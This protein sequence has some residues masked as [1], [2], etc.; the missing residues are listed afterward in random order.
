MKS[1]YKI[2][3]YTLVLLVSV[4][5]YAQ[6]HS[7]MIVELNSGAKTLNIQQEITFFNQSSDTLTSIFL[8]DW[9]NSYS[10]K[11]TPLAKRFSDEFYR[12]F[13]LAKEEERG[14]TN[15]LTIIDSNQLFVS[16]ERTEKN[17]DYIEVKLREKLLPNQKTT[18]HLTYITKI[19]SNKFTKYGFNDKGEMNLK[20]WFLTP[21][22]YEN[23]DF[24][25]YSNN[26]L[27]DISNAVSSYDIDLKTPA[28]LEITSDLNSSLPKKTG[29]FSNYKLSGNNRTD[30]SLFVE[31]KSSFISFKNNTTEVLTN[32]KENKISAIQKAVIVD[33]VMDYV[34]TLIGKYPHEK[35]IV[36]QTDYE[37]NPFYGLNQLPSFLSPFTDEFIFEIK[38]LKTY[39]NSYLKNSLRL[40]PRKDNWIY[41]GIQ[42]YAMMKY[43]D[44]NHPNT[45]MFGSVSK[46]RLLKSYNLTNL[47]FNEQ[48]SYFYMLMA[49]KNLD[50]P[51]G[52]PKNSLIKFN[53]QIASKY[54]AGL[55]FRFLDNY[56]EHDEV[57]NS[58]RQFYAENKE[59]QVSR[60]DF[61]TI[62]KFNADKDINWFF[63]TIV[64]SREIID[65]KFADVTKTKDS[66]TFSV[67]NKTNVLIP[68]PVY[69]VKKGEI[70]FKKWL[71]S[72][73]TD[74]TFTIER[75]NADKIVLNYNNEV[76][77]YNLR[78]NW[79]KLEGF[80]PN[81]RP[82]KFVFMK[83]L[84]DPYYN[85]ILYVPS[86]TYNYY[87][88]LSPGLRLHNKTILDKPF[89]FDINPAYSS[90]TDNFSGSAAF[91]VNQNYRNSTLFNVRYSVSG[92]Y[93]HYAP[94]AAYLK[95][96]PTVQL[97]I[98]EENF[99][100]NRKQLILLRQVLVNR[101]KSNFII[102]NST[103]NYSVFD[104]KYF[105]TRTEVT[106]HFSFISDL[107]LSGKFGKIASEI[108]YRKLFESKRQINLRLYA[109][110][111]LY[112]TTA[113]DFFSFALDRPTD[114][115]FDYNYYGR[116][117]SKGFYSQQFIL[118]EGGFKSKLN[119][120]F[121]NQW[122][123]T[124]NGSFNIW[125][126]MELYG[127]IGL[128]KNRS[129]NAR[130]VYDSGIRLN[131]VTDYFEL[132]F[133]IYSNNG[134]EIAQNNYNEKIRFVVTFSPK[135]LINLFNR[136]WF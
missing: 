72:N 4:K 19:P 28:A 45:K 112:N 100:D 114:Y 30:F 13:H 78:N 64:S 97:R 20:N 56:L 41:D 75:K 62:L 117:E 82:V 55:S 115:L 76:P 35:I 110:S 124:L 5:Q 98:R 16:W 12:G 58:I 111:F 54:R 22:R 24:I 81:N 127:D 59:K 108:E 128:I 102:D 48:Y 63:K 66:I 40:N 33:R 113:S 44:E 84:E 129:Q 14:S 68:I 135:T 71:D 52:D 123:T 74:S 94:D 42:V 79:K 18:L 136:K 9:N 133:P 101:E 34:N 105:N 15:N 1:F 3:I 21:A 104:A 50:Q 87:D 92:S 118:A 29:I 53:E 46:L 83:D 43:I 88:G 125:N 25:R 95:I 65:Y 91:V 103:E 131:L 69:G 2:A 26:N 23:H 32:L 85:Q 61:E 60:T 121:A 49:R 7:K 132:Y 109:G 36:S 107:Q 27:D 126:W 119:T 47:S 80:F 99:R 57:N 130:F 77:E 38:F 96:N 93:F 70:V 8:N 6:H 122:I 89:I 17:P 90:K 120:P 106:N 31:P 116:S 10:D 51:L 134:W 73:E 86:L 37:K 11:N 67:K 39:L